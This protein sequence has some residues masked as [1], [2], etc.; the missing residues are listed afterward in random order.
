MKKLSGHKNIE[1][2]KYFL[3]ISDYCRMHNIDKDMYG[4]GDFLNNFENEVAEI[5]GMEA[6]LFL[7]SGVMAQLIAIKIWGDLKESQTFSCHE[8]SHLLRH[9]EDSYKELLNFNVEVVGDKNQVPK[10]NDLKSLSENVST[11]IHELPMRHLGGDLP[12]I[13]EL[14]EMKAY[15]KEK[16]IKFHID[17][18]RVF[19][20]ATYY[21][22]PI[23][24]IVKGAD[25]LFIS[26]Y[27]GFGSTSGS[28]LFGSKE[29][30]EKARV[31]LRRFGGNL[32]QLFPLAIPAKINFDKRKM[33]FLNWKNKASEISNLLVSELNL[34]VIPF[35]TK[36]NMFHVY[37]P[38]SK[39]KLFTEFQKSKELGIDIRIGGWGE[40]ESGAQR[41]EFTVGDGTMELDNNKIIEIFKLLISR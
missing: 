39:D 17:G 28:M 16:N 2:D 31:W 20:A 1:L 22:L 11:Y 35:P 34:E 29:F 12:E 5:V 19:E 40:N 14:E 25:S 37:L 4:K 23:N 10:L 33:D 8:S 6:G 15:C 41:L 18:A 36:T 27:K 24:E 7:P 26:F 21:N 32:F 3:E 9:E 30:I 38:C 13:N